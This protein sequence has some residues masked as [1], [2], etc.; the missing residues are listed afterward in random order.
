MQ[1][2]TQTEQQRAKG[3]IIW[4][5]SLPKTPWVNRCWGSLGIH[6]WNKQKNQQISQTR[7]AQHNTSILVVFTLE[8]E[9]FVGWAK[10]WLD[11]CPGL[12][13]LAHEYPREHVCSSAQPRHHKL[14]P[15]SWTPVAPAYISHVPSQ[16]HLPS[17]ALWQVVCPI[18]VQREIRNH[19]ASK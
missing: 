18:T 17:S 2:Q 8:V 15:G 14:N 16:A 10:M 5:L 13:L 9:E 11:G 6:S 4:W 1:C 7:D 12:L 19:S 3:L